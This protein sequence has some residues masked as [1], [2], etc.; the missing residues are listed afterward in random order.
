MKLFTKAFWADLAERTIATGAQAAIAT[1][2]VESGL[3]DVD[4][5]HVGSISGL[6]ALIASLKCLALIRRTAGEEV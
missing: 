3:T 1:L 6:A 5:G 4:W 2:A